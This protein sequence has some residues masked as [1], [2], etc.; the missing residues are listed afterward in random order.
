MRMAE[1]RDE[2]PMPPELAAR[3]AAELAPVELS[4][5]RREALRAQLLQRCAV[6]TTAVL[7]AEEGEWVPTF[8]GIKVKT[9]RLDPV[10]R[11][12]TT[13]W[14]IEPGARVP[15]HPH[16]QSEECLVLEGSILHQGVEYRAGDFLLAP[17]GSRHAPFDSPRGALL[18]IRGEPVPRF[19]RLARWAI[20][21][22]RL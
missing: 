9:L 1:R 4:G 7:R 2:Q 12:Q 8:E 11:T 21:L 6:P 19:G 10:A 18:L 5:E 14:R 15:R 22:L 13:L 3:I 20:R 17:P 16:S